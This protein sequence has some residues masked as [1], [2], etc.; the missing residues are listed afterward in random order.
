M[1][2]IPEGW[3]TTFRGGSAVIESVYV[4]PESGSVQS[5]STVTSIGRIRY[6]LRVDLFRI[7][8]ENGLTGDAGIRIMGLDGESPSLPWPGG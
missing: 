6:L 7:R 8:F 5:M 1:E 2:E 4:E 3:T